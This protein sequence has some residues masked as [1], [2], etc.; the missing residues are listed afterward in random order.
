LPAA[1]V[2]EEGKHHRAMAAAVRVAIA[3]ALRGLATGSRRLAYRIEPARSRYS[4][5]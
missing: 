2:V 5:S 3:T 1:P 4:P